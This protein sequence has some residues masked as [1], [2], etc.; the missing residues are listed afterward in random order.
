M[1]KTLQV[2]QLNM[3]KQREC[4]V[5][6]ATGLEEYAALLISEP[7]VFEMDEKTRTRTMGHHSW[8]VGGAKPASDAQRCRV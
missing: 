3:Q 4:S 1:S 7:C 5:M 6:N 8:T 2:L